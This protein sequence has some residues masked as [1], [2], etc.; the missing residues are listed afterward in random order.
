MLSEREYLDAILART[1]AARISSGR[2]LSEMAVALSQATGDELSKD[3]YKEYE[4]R[5]PLPHFLIEPFCTLTG[6]DVRYFV[7]G[8]QQVVIQRQ[9]ARLRRA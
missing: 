7:T 6:I 5:S 4:R 3:T 1:K 9:A 2:S 8:D